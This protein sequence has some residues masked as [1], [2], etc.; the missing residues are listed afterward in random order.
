M[1][2]CPLGISGNSLE[3]KGPIIFDSNR[4]PPALSAIAIKPMNRAMIPTKPILILTAVL[5]VSIIPSAFFVS[6]GWMERY[7]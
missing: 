1:D 4:M 5:T 3:K 6:F 7:V 2:G